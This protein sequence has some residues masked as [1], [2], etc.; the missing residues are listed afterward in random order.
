MQSFCCPTILKRTIISQTFILDLL[1]MLGKT[2]K[3]KRYSPKW[4]FDGDLPWLQGKKSKSFWGSMR[5]FLVEHFRK[6]LKTCHVSIC[7]QWHTINIMNNDLK[8]PAFHDLLSNVHDLVSWAS[9]QPAKGRIRPENIWRNLP[10]NIAPGLPS[11]CPNVVS[12][13]FMLTRQRTIFL[14]EHISPSLFWSTKFE[15]KARK[16]NGPPDLLGGNIPTKLL[17]YHESMYTKLQDSKRKTFVT[18]S[19]SFS[20]K[21]TRRV[22]NF[23]E[24]C[25]EFSTKSCGF[26]QLNAWKRVGMQHSKPVGTPDIQLPCAYVEHDEYPGG[27]NPISGGRLGFTRI[28]ALKSSRS[29]VFLEKTPL[30]SY[31]MPKFFTTHSSKKDGRWSLSSFNFWGVLPRCEQLLGV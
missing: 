10:W 2:G 24:F 30:L 29:C 28:R 11:W 26:T 20:G 8:L 1:N 31:C 23:F 5:N 18:V 27:W 22:W 21:K 14:S 4:W 13:F 12:I 7:H 16:A 9:Y 19:T 25:T 3:S 6:C 17:W 15:T